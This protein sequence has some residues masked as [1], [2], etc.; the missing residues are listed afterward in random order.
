M[1]PPFR[2]ILFD[3]DNTLIDRVA[4]VRYLG[5]TL[6]ESDVLDQTKH[7]I[8]NAVEIFERIDADG[9]QP[10]K[11]K[12]FTD[13]ENLPVLSRPVLRSGRSLGSPQLHHAHE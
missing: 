3:L 7:S 5:K 6:Y 2:Y 1:P 9:Y 4:G 12:L 8:E 11:L 13:L 10:D